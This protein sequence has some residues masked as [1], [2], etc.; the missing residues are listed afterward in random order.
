MGEGTGYVAADRQ[1]TVIIP[2]KNEQLNIRPCIESFRSIADE[3]LVA[4]SGSTDE[5]LHIV[6]RLGGC[7]II[8]REYIHS[9]DFK[10]WAIPQ[11]THQWVLIVDADERVTP[12]LAAEITQILKSNRPLDGYWIYRA[13]YFM[14]HPIRYCGW[15]SDKVLRLFR[16]DL[17]RY[18]GDN[19]HAEVE[20]STGR[21]GRLQARL[22]HYGVRSY[23]HYIP[24]LQR[25]T[26]FQAQIW[27]RNGRRWSYLKLL[28]NL[29][30]RF[31]QTYLLRGGFLD[32]AAGLQVCMITA[33]ISFQKQ[34]RLWEQQCGIA[35]CDAS[36]LP[37][38][39]A[40]DEERPRSA[41]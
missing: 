20:V 39:T 19:D 16:R 33:F 26:S 5:T 8:E 27:N 18:V 31:A 13:N 35:T 28:L 3:I 7:R 30:L 22:D 41:A 17:G 21:A 36:Q 29:P 6:R 40:G 12:E 34:A 11:A 37:V 23:D 1:L 24:K 32:G 15:G 38:A 2:C 4:D 25:Y 14:G 10:N 9:G